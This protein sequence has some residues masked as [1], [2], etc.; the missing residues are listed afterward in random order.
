MVKRGID[1]R[2]PRVLLSCKNKGDFLDISAGFLQKL[3]IYF[4]RDPTKA[5][6]KAIAIGQK[7]KT[8]DRASSF[9]VRRSVKESN[10]SRGG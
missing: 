7:A 1:S 10:V 6:Y 9:R 3:T 8:T 5:E 4:D 2:D